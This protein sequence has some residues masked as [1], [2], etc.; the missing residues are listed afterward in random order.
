MRHLIL[1]ALLTTLGCAS[2]LSLADYAPRS[3]PPAVVPLPAVSDLDRLAS[4]PPPPGEGR[5]TDRDLVAMSDGVTEYQ[6]LPFLGWQLDPQAA[7]ETQWVILRVNGMLQRDELRYTLASADGPYPQ[8]GSVFCGIADFARGSWRWQDVSMRDWYPP[9]GD[10]WFTGIWIPSDARP[11]SPAGGIY[12]IAV[13][14][15]AEA[16]VVVSGL[17]QAEWEYY[18]PFLAAPELVTAERTAGTNATLT[19]DGG[20]DWGAEQFVSGLLIYRCAGSE[21]LEGQAVH[22]G[23]WPAAGAGE[24]IDHDIGYEPAYTY[25]LRLRA[26]GGEEYV[27]GSPWSNAITVPVFGE[28]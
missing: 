5:S 16:Q 21:W 17:C 4:L 15:G 3:E 8:S 20:D 14:L 2:P 27:H 9:M 23:S 11:V 24:W 6:G 7:G 13:A 28:E 12:L 19:L 1:I 18:Q 10:D 25:C 26:G 22:V